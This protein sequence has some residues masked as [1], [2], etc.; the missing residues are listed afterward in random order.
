MVGKFVRNLCR[1]LALAWHALRS[2]RVIYK[3]YLAQEPVAGA[4]PGEQLA[5]EIFWERKLG[6]HTGGWDPIKVPTAPDS[7]G[8]EGTPYLLLVEIFRHLKLRMNDVFVDVGCG[9]GRVLLMALRSAV[10]VAVGVELNAR[11]LEAARANLQVSHSDADRYYLF[12][13]FVQDFDFDSATVLFLFNPFGA[14]T[15]RKMLDRVSASLRRRPRELRIVYV[16]PVEESVLAERSW[17]KRTEVWLRDA[18]PDN[19]FL[20]KRPHVVS[21]WSS[22]QA[23]AC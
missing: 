3:R 8:Y 5:H 6:T 4:V 1:S 21:F 15:M 18:W 2:P 9:K 11:F 22:T 17:L 10:G 12:H 13:G 14:P 20:P 23:G 19:R 16:N 7:V